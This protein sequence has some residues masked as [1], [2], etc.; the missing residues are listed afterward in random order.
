MHHGVAPVFHSE[1]PLFFVIQA[2]SLVDPCFAFFGV[3]ICFLQKLLMA[4]NLTHVF[5]STD[6]KPAQLG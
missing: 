5:H 3:Q 6:L 4:C 1:V 2:R